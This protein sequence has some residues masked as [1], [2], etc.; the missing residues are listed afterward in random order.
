VGT[1]HPNEFCGLGIATDPLLDRADCS[2]DKLYG[3][4][5]KLAQDLVSGV[6][7]GACWDSAFYGGVVHLGTSAT[8]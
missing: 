8:V 2:P 7:S 4:G 5:R 3:R 6:E 1:K